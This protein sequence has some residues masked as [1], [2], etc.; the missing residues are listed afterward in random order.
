MDKGRRHLRTRLF[1]G[2]GV[3][4]T[5]IMLL[6]FVFHFGFFEGLQRQWV[7]SNFSIRGKQ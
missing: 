5:G 4:A 6:A 7:D 1:L 2:V 3:V